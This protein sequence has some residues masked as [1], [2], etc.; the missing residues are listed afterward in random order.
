MI[1]TQV[2]MNSV[3]GIHHI[4]AISSDPQETVR[5]YTQVLGLRLVKKTVNQD[6]TSTYHLFFGDT[7]GEPGMDLTFFTFAPAVQGQRGSGQVSLI[8]F[9]V[10]EASLDFWSARFT[11]LGVQHEDVHSSFGTK[12]VIFYDADDQ[13][14]ELVGVGE[15]LDQMAGEIWTDVIPADAA[16]RSFYSAR[17]SLPQLSYVDPILMILGYTKGSSEGNLTQYALAES[18]R[19]VYLE[20][21]TG[22]HELG[23]GAAGTVHHIAFSVSDVEHERSVRAALIEIG[24]Y[25]TD[26]INRFYFQSVYFRIPGGILFEL[27]TMGP[28]FTADEAEAELGTHLSL[29]PFLEGQRKEIEKNLVTIH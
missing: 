7:T 18:H 17:L 26:V 14:L 11:T 9:A 16:I 20:V 23:I 15:E 2:N 10:P 28:G 24:L 13:R 19:A 8:S 27:A 22:E 21:E 5:F 6:D 12:R 4:T 25:P 1:Y 3:H 29:P